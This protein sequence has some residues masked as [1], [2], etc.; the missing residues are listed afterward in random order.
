MERNTQIGKG[1]WETFLFYFNIFVVWFLF[2]WFVRFS[3]VVFMIQFIVMNIEIEIAIAF[4][5][6]RYYIR[7][8]GKIYTFWMT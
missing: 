3:F 5:Y 7:D 8:S 4:K 1:K 6:E 2:S